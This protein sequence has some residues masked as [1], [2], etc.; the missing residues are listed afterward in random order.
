MR[1]LSCNPPYG[2][3][4]AACERFPDLG[5]HIETRG[6]WE[7]RYRGLLLIHQTAGLGGMGF[8]AF[9]ELCS[10]EPFR[11]ALTAMRYYDASDLPRGAIV[12]VCELVGVKTIEL[13]GLDPATLTDQERAFG[14]YRPGRKALL[15]ANIR[16]LPSPIRARGGQGLWIPDAETVV[17]VEAQ[18]GVGV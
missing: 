11:T 5:K 10:R 4:I 9:Q 12:A 7:Y 2:T 1:A 6:R 13:T 18:L 8:E 17:A 16:A 14:D 3:L 15:L